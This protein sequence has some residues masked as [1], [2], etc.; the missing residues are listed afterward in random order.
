LISSKLE[1]LLAVIGHS[2]SLLA[3]LTHKNALQSFLILLSCPKAADMRFR[4]CEAQHLQ[5]ISVHWI[6][7]VV[8]HFELNVVDK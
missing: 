7:V 3:A 8:L 4:D 6:I 2:L 5:S 1:L